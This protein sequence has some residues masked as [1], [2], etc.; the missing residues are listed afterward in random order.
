MGTVSEPCGH[1]SEWCSSQKIILFTSLIWHL[2]H[3]HLVC[4]KSKN[5]YECD[6]LNIS[7]CWKWT[8]F[9]WMKQLLQNEFIIYLQDIRYFWDFENEK[10]LKIIGSKYLGLK[11]ISHKYKEIFKVKKYVFL[12]VSDR[13]TKLL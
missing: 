5:K 10:F 3:L 13:N 11:D 6:F 2:L 8:T 7:C 12:N 1:F 9:D 4:R